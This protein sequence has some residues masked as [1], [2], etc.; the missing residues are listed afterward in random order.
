MESKEERRALLMEEVLPRVA[1]DTADA[2]LLLEEA[3]PEDTKPRQ[4]WL[5]MFAINLFVNAIRMKKAA[6]VGAVLQVQQFCAL[7]QLDYESVKKSA[8]MLI[9][10]SDERLVQSDGE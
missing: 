2:M 1:K 10:Q 3:I 8:F 4:E 6:Q 9:R 7:A 5:L